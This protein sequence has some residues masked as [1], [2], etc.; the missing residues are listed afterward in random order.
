MVKLLL[1]YGARTD[2]K[3]TL[4]RSTPLSWAE[5]GKQETTAAMLRSGPFPQANVA[6]A[7]DQ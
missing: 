3:D 2:V 7:E 1:S 6:A 5:H 4:Y